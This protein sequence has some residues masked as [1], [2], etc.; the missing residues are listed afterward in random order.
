MKKKTINAVIGK[1]MKDWWSSIEDEDLRKRVEKETVV[2]GGCIASMLLGEKVSDFDVYLGTYQTAKDL[3]EYY[4]K[5]FESKRASGVPLSIYVKAESERVQIVVQSA[6]VASEEGA[7]TDYQ[8]FESRP[9]EEAQSYVAEVMDDAAEI[10]DRYQETE[11]AALE[12]TDGPPYRPVFL[13]T[14]AIT[15]SHRVQVIIRF[16][17]TPEEIHA[18]YDFV[19]CTN[20]WTKKTGVVLNQPALESLLA[21]ELRYVGSRYPI[22]SLIRTRKFVHRGWTINA[23]Q[24]VKMAFQ[25]GELDLSKLDVL[26]DQLTGVDVAYFLEVIEKLQEKDK[27]RVDGAYLLEIIDRMF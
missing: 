20:Y 18:N 24:F 23:G 27:E 13:S 5:R 1:K 21:K 9:P 3:A 2:T 7:E 19:H 12:E 14:N 4:V 6:G 16:F 17:G 10:E 11:E 15:L 26:R 22:C 25:V 8:Y